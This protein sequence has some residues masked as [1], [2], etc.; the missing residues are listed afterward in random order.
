MR[1]TARKR[2]RFKSSSTNTH[3]IRRIIG[4][5]QCGKVEKTGGRATTRPRIFNHELML[6]GCRF[7]SRGMALAYRLFTLGLT[8]G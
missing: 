8:V 6:A 7:C 1:I 4:T 3:P 5:P 2:R